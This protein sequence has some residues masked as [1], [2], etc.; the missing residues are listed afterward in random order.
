M[1]SSRF[2][3]L[4]KA[5]ATRSLSAQ[6]SEAYRNALL[7]V[8]ETKVT[9]LANG[10]RVASEQTAHKT[11]T[12]GLYIDAGSRF[13]TAENNGTAHFLEHMLFK[14][15]KKRTQHQLELELENM[16]AM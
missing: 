2:P 5:T 4:A 9:T 13:E 3:S 6:A 8:P 11:A 1:M 12:V 14:G 15:T 7:T 16:G 10:L